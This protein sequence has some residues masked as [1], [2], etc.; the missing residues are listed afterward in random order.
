VLLLGVAPL[1]AWALRAA[2]P[3]ASPRAAP[4]ADTPVGAA[5]RSAALWLLCAAFVLHSL[6][7]SAF[8]AHAV[9]ALSA[10]GL[11]QAEALAVLVT[12]GPAQVAGRLLFVGPGRRFTPRGVGLTVIG[13]LPLAFALL[14][15]G[16]GAWA[17]GAFGVLFGFSAGV[18]TVV[19]G[20]IVPAYFG[21]AHV[22]RI[23]ALITTLSVFARAAAPLAAAAV[24]TGWPGYR[25]LLWSLAALQ[26]GAAACFVGARPPLPRE[27]LPRIAGSPQISEGTR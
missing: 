8:W 7:S 11:A 19:R 26:L 22:G 13:A 6:A 2:A 21:R 27:P 15:A 1:H 18:L 24:L 4:R 17:M 23:G 16:R 12:I 25:E 3:A 10:R 14:A 20:L 5:L 9:P